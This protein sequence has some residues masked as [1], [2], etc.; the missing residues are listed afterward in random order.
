MTL[1]TL[2][3]QVAELSK[4]IEAL[5]AQ[6]KETIKYPIYCLQ[7]DTGLVVKFTDLQK[8]IVVKDSDYHSVGEYDDNWL[9]HTAT[10]NWT[11]LD[12]CETTG[13]FD[14]QLVWCWDKDYSHVRSLR[15]YNAKKPCTFTVDGYKY[16]F[17]YH[18]YEPYEGNWPQWAQDAFKTLER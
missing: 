16:G 17:C 5:E 8:G 4:K 14:G 10:E 9:S 3:E 18:N 13:F 12:V 11:Q 6:E 2:K 15:F 1:Q 7:Q